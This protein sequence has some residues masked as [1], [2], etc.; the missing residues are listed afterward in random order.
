MVPARAETRMFRAAPLTVLC[1]AAALV[2]AVAAPIAAQLPQNAFTTDVTP[3]AEASSLRLAADSLL[4]NYSA[5]L[6]APQRARRQPNAASPWGI[7]MEATFVSYGVS[8]DDYDSDRFNV[9]SVPRPLL[10]IQYALTPQISLDFPLSFSYQ[11]AEEQDAFTEI[12]LGAI[13]R[14]AFGGDV[15][16]GRPY[17]GAGGMVMRQSDGGE[18]LTRFA[19]EANL[20]YEMPFGEDL[21][22]RIY[23]M[24]GRIF[25]K[26][27]FPAETYFGL[28][29]GFGCDIFG[30]PRPRTRE[31]GPKFL[32]G[33]DF[34]RES[35]D[36]DDEYSYGGTETRITLPSP[37]AGLYF[38]LGATRRVSLGADL[39][40]LRLSQ[41]DNSASFLDLRPGVQF[42][43]RGD[44]WTETGF[45]LTGFASINRQS[46]DIG[47]DSESGT[48]V[49]FGAGAFVTTPFRNSV[50]GAGL[51]Y[52][53]T[54]SNDDLYRPASNTISLRMI[55][56][57][58]L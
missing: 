6:P 52:L 55:L 58:R 10:R 35:F 31:G 39:G 3:L 19:A 33:F 17:V 45:R 28:G 57:H 27:D 23:G 46:L 47:G 16:R 40:F 51:Q 44:P 36:D 14:Y 1:S 48:V 12:T 56:E 30:A 25:E 5:A 49:G 42:N 2:A 18:S 43:V 9:I 15:T 50:V 41:G 37:Y 26:D 24:F 20:G 13:P 22:W 4:P 53:R 34:G 54:S 29:T 11:K 32:I 7:A 21:H 38:P 8:G